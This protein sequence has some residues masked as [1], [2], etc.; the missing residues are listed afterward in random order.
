MLFVSFNLLDECLGT[1]KDQ[2][3]FPALRPRS[4]EFQN[5]Q[6]LRSNPLAHTIQIP[7]RARALHDLHK[8][9]IGCLLFLWGLSRRHMSEAF[10]SLLNCGGLDDAD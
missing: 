1:E 6:Q 5:L 10:S 8:L 7:S 3:P 9:P 4:Q 2:S